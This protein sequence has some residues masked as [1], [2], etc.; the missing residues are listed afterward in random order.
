MFEPYRVVLL[1]F[2]EAK[3][4]RALLR[5]VARYARLCGPW[6][7]YLSSEDP[8][9]AVPQLEAF[10]SIALPRRPAADGRRKG[11]LH[12]LDQWRA[13]GVIGRIQTAETAG[14]LLRSKLPLITMDL[15]AQQ[16]RP[17]SPLSKVSEIRPDSTAAGRLA[18]EHFLERG[19]QSFA[20]SGYA[21]RLW[22]QRRLEGFSQRLQDA[23][24]TCEVYD[25]PSV[26]AGR[27]WSQEWPRVCA[28]LQSLKKPVGI[29]ACN[30]VR[31]RQLLDACMSCGLNVPEQVAVIG[32]DDDELICDLANPP[33][34]SVAFDGEQA[35]FRAAEHLA[36]QMAGEPL[37]AETIVVEPLRVN[38]RRS[39]DVIAV[40]DAHVSAAMR[41]IRENARRSIGVEDVVEQSQ[42]SRRALEIRFQQR[43]G[44]GIREE[45]E[46]ARLN[47]VRQF[48][49][50]TDVP[51][52]KIA[53]LT[54]FN[55]LPYLSRVFR[56]ESG[57]T[58]SQYRRRHRQG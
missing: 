11:L 37:A 55:Q 16:L 26:A 14:Q 49:V 28:W 20:Y 42:V 5:G 30:D 4:D 47:L 25:P 9:L 23:C 17:K 21:G 1:L 7:F 3:Y 8:R 35:G 46:R 12:N 50:E 32:V 58:L 19:F 56:R 38:V 53:E 41:F 33:L 34:S 45:I 54:G 51:A 43:L 39:T 44:R 52:W 2:T 31:G 24:F 40:E 18:A 36:R 10:N 6:L 57:M 27:N 48:L 15:S 13:T 29:M 22:S